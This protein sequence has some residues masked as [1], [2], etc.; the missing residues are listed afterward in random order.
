MKKIVILFISCL[1][2]LGCSKM[3]KDGAISKFKNKLESEKS[4]TMT[5]QMDIVSNEEV[6][7]YDVVVDYKKDNCYKASLKNKETNHEQIILRND[8]GVYVITPSLNKSFKFQSEWPFNSS[9]AYILESLLKDLQNDSNV[10]FEEKD[11]K[12][13]LS[14]T[15]NYPNNTNLV[16][17]K[18]TFNKDMIPELV[19]V[20]DKNA[21][22]SI[23][24]KISK[25]EFG[26]KLADE[27]FEVENSAEEGNTTQ[28]SKLDEIVYPMYLPTGTKFKSEET[29]K[30]DNS[31]R[32]I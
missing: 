3:D 10:V 18:I 19:Q 8:N 27:Y 29:V 11:E 5:G 26:S 31:E 20:Y 9:Q 1:M 12:Y 13:Y 14:S 2:L 23:T 28:T 15:V 32:V 25:I 7:K 22:E 24:F 4:Y 30:T 16:S 6:Y 17:Q 21:L